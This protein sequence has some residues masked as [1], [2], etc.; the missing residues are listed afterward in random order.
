M[1]K[2]WSWREYTIL[3]PL[4]YQYSKENF[5]LLLYDTE[6]HVIQPSNPFPSHRSYLLT[7]DSKIP[8]FDYVL[9]VTGERK[10]NGI[11]HRFKD[12]KKV[13]CVKPSNVEK[14]R[15]KLG[16]H[17]EDHTH[18]NLNYAYDNRIIFGCPHEIDLETKQFGLPFGFDGDFQKFVKNVF[19][20]PF[21]NYKRAAF[22]IEVKTEKDPN[23]EPIRPNVERAEREIN[24][25][26]MVGNDGINKILLLSDKEEVIGNIE[27]FSDE[28]K[29]IAR[30]FQHLE[31]YPMIVTHGGNNFDCPYLYNRANLLEMENVPITHKQDWFSFHDK[32]HLDT[33]QFF[34]HRIPKREIFRDKYPDASLGT[35]APILLGKPKLEFPD[36]GTIEQLG[37]Y[38]WNDA[39]LTLELTTFQNN[40]AI[41]LLTALMRICNMDVEFLINNSTGPWVRS[42]YEFF[43]RMVNWIIPSSEDLRKFNIGRDVDY[44]G[45][46][47]L[48]PVD[49]GTVGTHFDVWGLDY[50]SMY[51][52]VLITHNVSYDTYNCPHEECKLKNTIPEVGHH[53]CLKSKGIIPTIFDAYKTLRVTYYKPLWKK[54]QEQLDKAKAEG[55]KEVD[56]LEAD[57]AIAEC[58]THALRITLNTGYGVFGDADQESLFVLPVAESVTAL[59]RDAIRTAQKIVISVGGK[60][61]FGHT[62]SLYIKNV[63]EQQVQD[64]IKKVHDATGLELEVDKWYKFVSAWRK[65]NYIAVDKYNHVKVSGLVG[66]KKHIPKFIKARFEK[67]KDILTTINTPE[68]LEMAKKNIIE[69]C[70][71]SA[72]TLKNGKVPIE[73]LSYATTLGKEPEEG[74]KSS[75]LYRAAMLYKQNVSDRLYA[76]DVLKTVL[77]KGSPTAMPTAMIKDLAIL[78]YDKY[79]ENMASI[80][81]P[82]TEPLGVNVEDAMNGA[83]SQSLDKWFS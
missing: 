54:L 34:G 72:K 29:L 83:M 45:A 47:I 17:W 80:F 28:R 23:G 39:A 31:P 74:S 20:L 13:M 44:K 52:S 25:A 5:Y 78:N 22:D 62:D 42:Y 6:K 56:Q 51:P 75:Q 16:T 26:T 11:E 67:L 9:R 77:T 43:H 48:S 68:D 49:L 36:K 19:D 81:G 55:A 32:I 14:L 37:F 60:P 24:A 70:T 53:F 63:N 18:Y 69:L 66:K 8:Q 41:N 4:G 35:L 73:E 2:S 57:T 46:V 30:L 12:Y 76:G 58:I 79:I 40:L 71:D 61:L 33:A 50:A 59:G 64:I 15:E 27:Y 7:L 1:A 10:Y 21:T 65:G 3:V 38:C 82:I